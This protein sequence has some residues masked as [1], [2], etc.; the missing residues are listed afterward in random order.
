MQ[1][2]TVPRINL[3]SR[4]EVKKEVFLKSRIIGMP[5]HFSRSVRWCYTIKGHL[6]IFIGQIPCCCRSPRH[7]QH[8][9]SP[10]F[11]LQHTAFCS[12]WYFRLGV[13]YIKVWWRIICGFWSSRMFLWTPGFNFYFRVG[14]AHSGPMQSPSSYFTSYAIP[15]TTERYPRKSLQWLSLPTYNIL[16]VTLRIAFWVATMYHY[17]NSMSSINY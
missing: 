2:A 12:I 7:W 15:H 16:P 10:A 6:D 13:K 3:I 17:N 5:L 4:F 8:S 9:V 11:Y 14:W 1:P